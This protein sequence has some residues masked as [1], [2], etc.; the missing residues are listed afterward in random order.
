[1]KPD[2]RLLDQL[3]A[4]ATKLDNR[5]LPIGTAEIRNRA[6]LDDAIHQNRRVAREFHP[7]ARIRAGVAH[8]RLAERQ[9]T[10]RRT[11]HKRT[12]WLAVAPV[13]LVAAIV[14]SVYGLRSASET[15]RQELVAAGPIP[16]SEVTPEMVESSPILRPEEQ[17]RHGHGLSD[18][19]LYDANQP[20]ASCASVVGPY[21]K[22]IVPDAVPDQ[23]TIS[24]G[25]I[26]DNSQTGIRVTGSPEELCVAF[27]NRQAM[28][29]AIPWC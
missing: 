17:P 10:S 25:P 14:A 12:A 21:V 26:V 22:S 2:Q 20:E 13:V 8:R 16:V 23:M 5:A 18:E 28:C 29:R 6:E 7:A 19:L 4:Q 11:L 1:M 15:G 9:R 27:F 24:L 3:Y